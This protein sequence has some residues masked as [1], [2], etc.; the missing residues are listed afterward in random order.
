MRVV[1]LESDWNEKWPP[2]LKVK[3]IPESPDPDWCAGLVL[4]RVTQKIPYMLNYSSA[5]RLYSFR[6]C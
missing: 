3:T 6:A 5:D 1:G 2:V 4:L